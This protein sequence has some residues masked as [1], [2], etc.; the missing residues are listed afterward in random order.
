ML[1]SEVIPPASQRT[2]ARLVPSVRP[3]KDT[4]S[5]LPGPPQNRVRPLASLTKLYGTFCPTSSRRVSTV[6]NAVTSAAP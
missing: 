3:L 5:L 1:T 2:L 4:A 6:V